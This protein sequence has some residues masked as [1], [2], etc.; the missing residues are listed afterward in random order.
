M[1]ASQRVAPVFLSALL[2]GLPVMACL[3]LGQMLSQDEKQ[4]CQQMA[5]EC[6]RANMPSSHS[7]CKT[8]VRPHDASL[9]SSSVSLVPHLTVVFSLPNKALLDLFG[10]KTSDHWFA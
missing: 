6:G 1:P 4:C 7:C 9:A 10:D 5:E 8:V 2:L 3:A